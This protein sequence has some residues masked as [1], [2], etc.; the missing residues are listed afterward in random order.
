[1]GGGRVAQRKVHSLL[2][3]GALVRIISPNFNQNLKNLPAKQ[4]FLDSFSL[5][6]K[7]YPKLFLLIAAVSD[8]KINSK[9]SQDTQKAEI[10]SMW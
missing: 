5:S 2:K 3:A 4:D 8:K 6:E 1:M 10:W 9:I 7:I